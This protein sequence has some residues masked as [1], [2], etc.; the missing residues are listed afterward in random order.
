MYSSLLLHFVQNADEKE[1]ASMVH[2]ALI[3]VVMLETFPKAVVDIHVTVLESDGSLGSVVIQ[4][5]SL[6]LIDAGIEVRDVV[7]ACTVVRVV[8]I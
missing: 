3:G 8:C 1:L 2:S 7:S 6:A 4:A 5:A